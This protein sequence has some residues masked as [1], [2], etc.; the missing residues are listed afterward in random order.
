MIKKVNM[1]IQHFNYRKGK[2]SPIK[3][4]NGLMAP[5]YKTANR[6]KGGKRTNGTVKTTRNFQN[7]KETD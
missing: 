2:Q 1:Y 7:G 6:N 3:R 5:I 4:G